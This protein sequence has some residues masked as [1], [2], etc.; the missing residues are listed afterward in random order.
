M[1]V[2]ARAWVCAWES[3]ALVIQRATRMGNI[4]CGLRLHHLIHGTIFGGGK[5][6]LDIKCVWTF[7][8]FIKTFLI[9]RRI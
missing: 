3:V 6:S 8:T 4:I 7:S 5:K 9:L 2:C 1:G